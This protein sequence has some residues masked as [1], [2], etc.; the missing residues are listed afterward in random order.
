MKA[1][2]K[3]I[4]DYNAISAVIGVILMVAI[5]V[6]IGAVAFVYFTGMLGGPAEEKEN[7]GIAVVQD[8]GRIKITLISAGDRIADDGYSFANVVI[9][10]NGTVLDES[11]FNIAN[12][13]WEIGESLYIGNS[14][15]TL[16]DTR[17]DVIAL[18]G[19]DYSITVTILDT[20]I[21]DDKV[22]VL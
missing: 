8:M 3:F 6:A 21:Y 2:R 17:G 13:G 16:D 9:R 7:A 18:D 12:T 14:N 15:P 11:G 5:T 10:L 22:T 1:N 20:V 19:A 4:N